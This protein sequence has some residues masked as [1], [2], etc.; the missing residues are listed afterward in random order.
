[1]IDGQGLDEVLMPH[2]LRE[3]A[4]VADGRRGAVIGPRGDVA[5]MCVPSWESPSVFSSLIGGSGV[6][7]IAPT[8]RFVWGGYYED[9]TLI[10]RSRW[11]TKDGELECR[12]ALS[13]PGDAH[14]A[15]LLRQ[16]QATEGVVE[17]RLVLNPRGNYDQDPIGDLD[18]SEDGIW[19]M[20]SGPLHLRLLGAGDARAVDDGRGAR[21]I[22]LELTLASGRR[23]DLVLEVSDRPIRESP[24]DPRER[25]EETETHWSHVVPDLSGFMA[26]R[27]A[28]H[29]YA[30]LAGLTRPSGGMAASVTTSL[31]ER[32]RA[33]GSYDYRFAWIRDQCFAGQAAAAAG[34]L[35]L[36]DDAV[37]FV[38]D[39]LLADGPDLR[40][41][42]TTSGGLVPEECDLGL[43]GYPGGV[44]VVGN[45][46]TSQFQLDVFGE[47]L[48]LL[49]AAA[50][51][52][53]LGIQG[54]DAAQVAIEAIA[55]RWREPD[56]GIWELAPKRWSHSA[57]QC[58]AGL[59]AV[60][61]AITGAPTDRWL[62]MADRILADVS[63]TGVHPSGRWQRAPDDDR[64]DAALLLP[65]IRGALPPGDPR[66]TATF[67]TVKAD[68]SQDGYLYRFRHDDRPLEQTEGAF[69][70]CGF[71]MALGC[72]KRGDVAEGRSWLERNRAACG[73]PGLFSEEFDVVQR[74][75]RGNLPQ[76]FVH[77]GLLE[78]AARYTNA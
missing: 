58:V 20:T 42:Y 71:W 61:S 23:H 51:H 22:E 27:D 63:S 76:A 1:M 12:E 39:R 40:P 37:A 65:A 53:R 16:L 48:L 14:R 15:I 21:Q 72:L 68:L 5:W 10:W 4:L 41:A 36:L 55:K 28:R 66:S 33:G 43:A 19:T 56:A 32:A 25:W 75:L 38:V 59:R 35:G 78:C 7:A 47:A 70:L 8:G 11:V 29:A 18:Q 60:S 67:D 3:Y 24:P 69:L 46:V 30:V 74:Q 50:N 62:A 77:A 73:P 54:W 52:S 49:A 26:R 2:V 64:V 57:L 31:P 34:A 9:G 45:K 44:D 6:Y 17:A 13:C